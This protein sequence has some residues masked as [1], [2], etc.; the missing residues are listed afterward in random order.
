MEY[1]ICYDIADDRLRDRVA[2][3]LLDY[4]QRVQESVFVAHLDDELHGRMLARVEKLV[5]KSEDRIHVFA[6]CNACEGKAL[7]IGTGELPEDPLF[8]II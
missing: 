1:V 7:S 4:G 8:V 6:L 2:R 3:A 5:E